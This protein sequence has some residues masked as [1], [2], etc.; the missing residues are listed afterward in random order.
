[1]RASRVSFLIALAAAWVLLLSG[2]ALAH[3]VAH[4]TSLNISRSPGGTVAPGTQVTF[5]GQLSSGKKA[6]IDFSKVKLIKVGAGVVASRHTDGT[7]H[8]EFTKRVH[9]TARWRV[10]FPGEVLNATHPHNHTCEASSSEK[11]RVPVS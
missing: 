2:V 3:T 1:M 5:S 8:Y 4:P 9:E 11:I 7:G 6:C 10:T